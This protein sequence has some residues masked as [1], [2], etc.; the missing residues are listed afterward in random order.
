[1]FLGSLDSLNK[2]QS[3]FES[4]LDKKERDLH[5]VRIFYFCYS[6]YKK[7]LYSIVFLIFNIFFFNQWASMLEASI[8]SPKF[9]Y[10][11]S[12]NS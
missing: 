7:F 9:H 4:Q 8:K 10:K 2:R 3:E 11:K 12:F 5:D 6:F 1:M